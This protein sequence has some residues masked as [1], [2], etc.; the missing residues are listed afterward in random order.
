MLSFE[1][2]DDQQELARTVRRF[3]QSRA[4]VAHSRGLMA[5]PLGYD[6]EVWDQ[7]A[8]QLGLQG[9]AVPEKFG[10]SGAGAVELGLVLREM[11]RVLYSGPFLSSA[12]FATSALLTSGDDEAM[13]E[14][15][16][17]LA[18]G[19]V[20]GAL[21]VA[22]STGE[23]RAD[24][25]ATHAV[26]ADGGWLLTGDKHFVVH[27]DAA[28]LIL[29]AART[30]NGIS[31][32]G[33][34]GDATGLRKEPRPVLD[35]TRPLASLHLT[36]TPARLLGDEGGAW[37][38]IESTFDRCAI[39]LAAETLGVADTVLEVTV[40][41]A[42]DRTQFDRPIGSFQAIKHKCA[43]LVVEIELARSAVN[44]ATRAVDSDDHDVRSAACIALAQTAEA[45]SHAAGE[46][47]QIHGGIGFTWEHD[48]HLYFKR[49]RSSA[50]LLGTIAAHRER[51]LQTI[52]V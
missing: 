11:G 15:L 34:A 19:E 40:Q 10:G 47:I 25:I 23:F 26:E 44:Y 18:S 38:G 13:A 21:A 32:F 52:G 9:L 14:Y 4:S 37:A 16:P 22:E 51:L 6:R 31:L 35:Q 29:V 24:D 50:A 48:A 43:D 7:L 8:G 3:L 1:L 27:G 5:D 28:S 20:I 2:D 12:G 30:E 36:S 39:A 46:S 17:G 49:A 42:K 41:Y 45:C 33:V